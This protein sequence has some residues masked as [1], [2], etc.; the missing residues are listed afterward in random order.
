MLCRIADVYDAMR[1]QRIYQKAFPTDRILAVLKR[2]DGTRFDQ[3]LVRRF[4]QLI[5]RYPAGTLVRLTS[6][7]IAVVL[8]VYAPDPFRPRV[9]VIVGRDGT[10]LDVPYDVTLWEPAGERSAPPA[11]AAPVDAAE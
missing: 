4:V 11:I 7:E 1:S 8:Q 2:N 6:G 3:H 10:R 5:G 9:R